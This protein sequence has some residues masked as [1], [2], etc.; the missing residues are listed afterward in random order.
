MRRLFVMLLLALVQGCAS[1][2]F[3]PVSESGIDPQVYLDRIG[4]VDWAGGTLVG[5]G[6]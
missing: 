3:P 1:R 2:G 5:G 4:D 6:A